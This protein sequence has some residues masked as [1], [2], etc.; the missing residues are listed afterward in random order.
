[1]NEWVNESEDAWSLRARF[2]ISVDKQ[3]QTHIKYV[4]EHDNYSITY[5]SWPHLHKIYSFSVRDELLIVCVTVPLR[6]MFW[7]TVAGAG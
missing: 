1:M 2:S 7:I 6:H 3:L 4:H 5:V